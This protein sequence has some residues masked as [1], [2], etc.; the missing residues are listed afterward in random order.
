MPSWNE[1]HAAA[2]QLPVVCTRKAGPPDH[3]G[4]AGIW[5]DENNPEQLASQILELLDHEVLR[6]EVGA[7]LLKRVQDCLCWDV[8][9]EQTLGIYE[10][11][12]RRGAEAS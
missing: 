8:I 12:S 6:Q 4:D 7:R 9:A 2:C 11:A 3:L 5:V 10:E 1:S